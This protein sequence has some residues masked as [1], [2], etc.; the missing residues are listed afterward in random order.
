MDFSYNKGPTTV[1]YLFCP[2]DGARLNTLKS[3]VLIVLHVPRLCAAL[4]EV[5][6]SD[7]GQLI[8]FILVCV[9]CCRPFCR[10]HPSGCVL[11]EE[12]WIRIQHNTEED[13]QVSFVNSWKHTHSLIWIQGLK[14]SESRMKA[15]IPPSPSR[16]HGNTSWCDVCVWEPKTVCRQRAECVCVWI[17]WVN[18]LQMV[19]DLWEDTVNR[20]C[21]G[22][23]FCYNSKITKN[24]DI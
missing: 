23:F 20:G 12:V 4:A 18:I 7:R 9:S 22:V 11:V 5:R 3:L 10:H 17:V 14:S 13:I 19:S 6:C 16:Y 15:F 24:E 2:D 8:R 21:S 1:Q